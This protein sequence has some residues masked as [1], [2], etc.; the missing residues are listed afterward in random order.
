[1][2]SP[3]RVWECGRDL[4][5]AASRGR[6]GRPLSAFLP[7]L[8]EES[9]GLRLQGSIGAARA[10]RDFANP[11]FLDG[12]VGPEFDADA[13]L[14]RLPDEGLGEIQIQPI[15]GGTNK[16]ERIEPRRGGALCCIDVNG[17]GP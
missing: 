17:R 4:W 13:R 8:K 12:L 3:S 6:R 11:V 1:M 10:G 5:A 2:A 16:A 15:L 14:P 7:R 9:K